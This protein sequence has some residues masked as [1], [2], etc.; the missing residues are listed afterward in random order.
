MYDV[1]CRNLGRYRV[2]GQHKTSTDFKNGAEMLIR[3]LKPFQQHA[4]TR[5]LSSRA[6]GHSNQMGLG[7]IYLWESVEEQF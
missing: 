5:N 3:A 7:A 4:G 6:K 1:I 2:Y